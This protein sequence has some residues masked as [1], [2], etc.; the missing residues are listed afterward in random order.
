MFYLDKHFASLLLCL[1][2]RK[3]SSTLGLISL[4]TDPTHFWQEWDGWPSWYVTTHQAQLNFLPPLGVA[5][6]WGVNH[7]LCRHCSIPLVDG[8]CWWQVNSLDY[9]C[10]RPA[11]VLFWCVSLSIKCYMNVLLTLLN[12]RHNHCWEIRGTTRGGCWFPFHFSFLP[13]LALL[14]L[15]AC[16]A[17]SRSPTLF[18]HSFL[19]PSNPEASEML[20][21]SWRGPNTLGPRFSSGGYAPVYMPTWLSGKQ[22]LNGCTCFVWCA[23]V[24]QEQ[25]AVRALNLT[26]VFC[27]VDRLKEENNRLETICCDRSREIDLM[28]QQVSKKI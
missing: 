24:E 28:R 21:Q 22:P 6:C 18:L 14:P 2:L 20:M 26:S 25:L 23:I 19:Y 12:H 11:W 27:E 15:F 5:L 7:A 1:V 9:A 8:P 17:V 13:V 4:G 3:N 16:T 10:Y